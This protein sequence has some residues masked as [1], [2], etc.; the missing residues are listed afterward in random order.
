VNELNTLIFLHM[1][2]RSRRLSRKWFFIKCFFG[3]F[4][5]NMNDLIDRTKPTAL[6]DVWEDQYDNIVSSFIVHWYATGMTSISAGW[7]FFFSSTQTRFQK[8]CRIIF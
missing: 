4:V 5:M 2:K 6:H 7:L 8:S 1:K 3:A